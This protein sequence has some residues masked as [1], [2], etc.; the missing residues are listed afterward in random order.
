MPEITNLLAFALVSLGMVLTPGPNMVYLV[1][2]SLSQGA[3]AGL[4]SLGGV[5]AGYLVY[6]LAAAFGITALLL[7]VPFAYDA[8]RLSGAL[9]LLWLAWQAVRPGGRS[10]FQPR[11]L[12]PDG[13]RRLF[14]MGFLTNLLNPKIA[15]MY[16]SLLP[17]FITP[18]HGS[19][20]VQSLVLGS[21]QTGISVGVNALLAVTAGSVAGFL[22]GRPAWMVAQRWLMGTV[23]AGLAVRMATEAR[24]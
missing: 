20:L 19:V 13:P 21:V 1:S 3:G 22:G 10:P 17:Q 12:P 15:V 4:V 9:Y 14:A 23:L 6:M 24:R 18:G 7:A 11:M 16:L 5:A 2:R 8:L